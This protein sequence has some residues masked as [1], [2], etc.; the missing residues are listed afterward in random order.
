MF[1]FAFG[2]C[3]ALRLFLASCFLFLC[4]G[5]CF[6]CVCALC[7]MLCVFANAC[8]C[9]FSCFLSSFFLSAINSFDL[10]GNRIDMMVRY[11]WGP[12]FVCNV[13]CV[14]VYVIVCAVLAFNMHT[15]VCHWFCIFF[16]TRRST[17]TARPCDRLRLQRDTR[18]SL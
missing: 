3:L 15:S 17:Y 5:G 18:V 1:W 16:D 8:V 7:L 9:F 11:F 14:Q 6:V 13:D 10:R 2:F 4:G 12:F